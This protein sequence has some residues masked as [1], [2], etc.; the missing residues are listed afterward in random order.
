MPRAYS[1]WHELRRPGVRCSFSGAIDDNTNNVAGTPMVSPESTAEGT[2]AALLEV[3][4]NSVIDKNQ[5]QPPPG[6]PVN[7]PLARSVRRI[8]AIEAALA[9]HRI[10][11]AFVELL[12]DQELGLSSVRSLGVGMSLL[13]GPKLGRTQRSVNEGSMPPVTEQGPSVEGGAAASTQPSSSR[14]DIFK[15]LQGP[16]VRSAE[17]PS[18]R[19]CCMVQDSP[20]SSPS[21]T[22]PHTLPAA[23]APQAWFAYRDYSVVRELGRGSHGRVFLLQ[24]ESTGLHVVTKCIP[25]HHLN[26]AEQTSQIEQ[27]VSILMR[28]RHL[29]VIEYIDTFLS[30]EPISVCIV[31]EYAAGGDLSDAI[32]EAKSQPDQPIAAAQIRDWLE[33]VCSALHEIHSLKVLHRDLA[34]KNILCT[35]A[36]SNRTSPFA[37]FPTHGKPKPRRKPLC[38]CAG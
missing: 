27:E 19:P 34:P 36:M 6:R 32:K 37:Y 4:A 12:I 25:L 17:A 15:F 38:V 26:N 28:V 16:Q 11:G 20:H 7:P 9:M 3:A 24:S 23:G 31:M 22:W 33:Q 2:P 30:P 8:R 10:T 13:S 29:H 5:E 14:L 1:N 35:T 18:H 21:L